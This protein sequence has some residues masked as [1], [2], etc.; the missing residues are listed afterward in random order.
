MV[1]FCRNGIGVCVNLCYSVIVL[2][3]C[4]Y[5]IIIKR[6]EKYI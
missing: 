4:I 1:S 3:F 6:N 2:E 5:L